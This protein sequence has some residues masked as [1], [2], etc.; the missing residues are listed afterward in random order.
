VCPIGQQVYGVFKTGVRCPGLSFE[1]GIASCALVKLDLVPIGDGCCI[2]A[3]VFK[4]G[5]EYDFAALP[6]NMKIR[7]AQ[8]ILNGTHSEVDLKINKEGGS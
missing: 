3:R 2:S 6:G 5:V 8:M 4:D 7:I 1:N